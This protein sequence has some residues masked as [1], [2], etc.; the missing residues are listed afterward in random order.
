MLR[1]VSKQGKILIPVA[2]RKKY[3][4]VAGS[5]VNFV[6]YGGMIAIIPA[7]KGPIGQAAGML[8]ASKSL[9]KYLLEDHRKEN[10]TLEKLLEEVTTQNLHS[11][12]DTGKSIGY[13]D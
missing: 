9:K 13:E 4:L 8:K 7:M 12:I 5:K 11:E 3:K 6:D 2:L 10:I 1:K